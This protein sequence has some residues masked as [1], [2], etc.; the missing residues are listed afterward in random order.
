MGE[1]FLINKYSGNL[2]IL[3]IKKNPRLK[4]QG[5]SRTIESQQVILIFPNG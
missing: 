5:F 1:A 3:E 2:R 4:G